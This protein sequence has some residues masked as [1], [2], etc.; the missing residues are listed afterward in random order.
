M[1]AAPQTVQRAELSQEETR[2]V[3]RPWYLDADTG[4]LK[5]DGHDDPDQEDQP[6]SVRV[7]RWI[8]D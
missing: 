4:E 5:P 2:D 3:E 1:G 6:A 7:A 8:F